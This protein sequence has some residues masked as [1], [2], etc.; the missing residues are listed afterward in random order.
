MGDIN[1]TIYPRGENTLLFSPPSFCFPA[2][3]LIFMLISSWLKTCLTSRSAYAW[4][5]T[6]LQGGVTSGGLA[7]AYSVEKQQLKK[8]VLVP[9]CMFLRQTWKQQKIVLVLWWFDIFL[10]FCNECKKFPRGPWP[11]NVTHSFPSFVMLPLFITPSAQ[12]GT[13]F[14]P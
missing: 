3:N 9:L 6:F 5:S 13:P 2:S 4:A 10:V 12:E 14:V 7:V 8:G 11:L 1:I